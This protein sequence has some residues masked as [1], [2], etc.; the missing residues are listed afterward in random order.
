[1]RQLAVARVS[2]VLLMV[3]S[4][5]VFTG[6]GPV[7]RGV[8]LTG[9]V[10]SGLKRKDG[11]GGCIGAWGGKKDKSA[12]ASSGDSLIISATAHVAGA[13]G[14]NWRSDLEVHNLGD[15]LA[16]FQV[17]LLEHGTDNTTPDEVELSLASGP[18]SPPRRCALRRVRR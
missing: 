5:L 18:E 9:W 14:T 16:V 2:C 17:L 15:D 8:H 7:H 12:A 13:Q 10:G 6:C 3:L 11:F 1:M 4:G